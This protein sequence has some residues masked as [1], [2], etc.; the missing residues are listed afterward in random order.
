MAIAT[1]RHGGRTVTLHELIRQSGY[2]QR[3]VAERAGLSPQYLC[4]IVRG[5][6][7]PPP[8]TVDAIAK[9]LFLPSDDVSRAIYAQRLVSLL[10]RTKM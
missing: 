7:L 8:W 4:D 2:K 5:R 1:R 6:T 9:V 10:T 3:E